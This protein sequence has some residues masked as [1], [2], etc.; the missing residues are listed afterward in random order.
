MSNNLVEVSLL[1]HIATRKSDLFVFNYPET[2]MLRFKT[3]RLAPVAIFQVT[4]F[5]NK[6][7]TQYKNVSVHIPKSSKSNTDRRTYYLRT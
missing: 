1:T 7:H 6:H 3:D 5:S 4:F 2:N